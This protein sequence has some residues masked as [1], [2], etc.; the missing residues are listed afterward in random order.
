MAEELDLSF[1]PYRSLRILW[2]YFVFFF[3]GVV[4]PMTARRGEEDKWPS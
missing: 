4:E 2:E 1:S 3:F